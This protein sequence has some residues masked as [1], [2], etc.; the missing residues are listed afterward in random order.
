MKNKKYANLPLDEVI[1]FAS[2]DDAFEQV[3][4]LTEKKVYALVYAVTGNREDALDASQE[5]F[6]RVWN[7]RASFRGESSALTWILSV[8]RNA[9][10]DIVRRR[11]AHATV[12]LTAPD[13]EGSIA[14]IPDDSEDARPDAEYIRSLEVA[15]VRRAIA[16]L[17]AAQREIITLRDIEG[18]TYAELSALLALPEGTV[19]SR[20]ARARNALKKL[21]SERNFF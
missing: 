2:D 8:A 9:A 14:D 1:L 20:L 12:S 10:I 11:D 13:D 21:L 17:P 3:V 15:E 5:T 6:I 7:A 4:L 19:K 16:A 18:L